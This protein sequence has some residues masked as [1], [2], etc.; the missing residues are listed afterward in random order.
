MERT[1]RKQN[2]SIEIDLYNFQSKSIRS[3]KIERM[4]KGANKEEME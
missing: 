4:E 3:L 1:S 2:G